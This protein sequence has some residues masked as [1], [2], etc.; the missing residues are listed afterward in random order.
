MKKV[1]MMAIIIAVASLTTG[2]ATI[3]KGKTQKVNIATSN[4]EQITVNVDGQAV[5]V[6][7]VVNVSRKGSNLIVGTSVKGCTP[8]TS[9]D[10]SVEPLFFGNI[11]F[12]GSGL[13][14]SSTD[15]ATGSMWKYDSNILV[16][17]K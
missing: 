13:F 2:C 15:Y 6:P 12:G 9:F 5:I 7:G 10:S 3:L 8:N 17:C 4:N 1:V 11:L 16:N 14:S